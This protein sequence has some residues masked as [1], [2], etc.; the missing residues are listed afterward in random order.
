M[1]VFE[2]EFVKNI[3]L[4]VCLS[5]SESFFI[6]HLTFLNY[7]FTINELSRKPFISSSQDKNFFRR[8]IKKLA[9][10]NLTTVMEIE[11]KLS[12]AA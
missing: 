5:M 12:L 9:P 10:L 7:F 8:G 11:P 6:T 2:E 1:K 4:F 3:F